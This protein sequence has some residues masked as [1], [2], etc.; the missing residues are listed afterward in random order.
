MLF[1][2][3][4][5]LRPYAKSK[6]M[7]SALFLILY[8]VARFLVEY[9]REPDVGIGIQLFGWMTRGQVLCV[10][11]ILLGL[12]LLAFALVRRDADGAPVSSSN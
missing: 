7:L 11:M 5:L 4:N 6:G 8:G 9:V 2:I 10:P 12:V 3:L 1:L